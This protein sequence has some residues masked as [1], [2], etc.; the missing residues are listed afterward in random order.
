[1]AAPLQARSSDPAPPGGQVDEPQQDAAIAS[2]SMPLQALRAASLCN[3]GQAMDAACALALAANFGS[4][5]RWR[6]QFV[7]LGKTVD[8]GAGWVLLMFGPNDGT[9]A[10]QVAT[11]PHQ[12]PAGGVP[13]LA[14]QRDDHPHELEP[15]AG[16]GAGV[17]TLMRLIDWPA[18]YQRYQQAVHA[19]SEPLGASQDDA[20]QA[21]LLDVRRA[22]VFANATTLIPGARW[23]DPATVAHWATDLPIGREVVV[24]CVHGHEVSRATALRLRGAGV[25]ARYLLGGISA[26]QAAGRPLTALV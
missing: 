17:D 3:G 22:G 25:K 16:T 11:N 15:R 24:Y 14:L 23:Q 12:L 13:L 21:L 4:V 5:E 19:A 20:A 7:A 6:D 9:L 8:G 2:A 10:N 18:F 1:M 26:W